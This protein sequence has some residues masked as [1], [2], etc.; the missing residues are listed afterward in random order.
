M[1]VLS[2][3]SV[4]PDHVPAELV[5]EDY[6]FVFGTITEADP[7]NELA[8]SVHQG[9]DIIYATNAYPGRTGAWVPR[10]M[11]DLRAIY[12][13]PETFSS[14]GFS[15]FAA[16]IGDTWINSPLELDPPAHGPFR[17]MLNPAFTPK[18]M[19]ALEDKIRQYAIGYI[20]KFAANGRCEFM[21]QMAFEF[22]IRV[23][24]ELMGLPQDRT[25]EFLEWEQ[26]MLFS[27]GLQ[28]KA[29]AARKVVTYLAEEIAAHRANPRD[30]LISFAINA[31]K[32]G[33]PLTDDEL[34]GFCFNLFIGGLDTVSTHSSLQFAHLAQ[35]PEHQAYL[36]ENPSE[37]PKAIEEFMR[38]YA[39][40]T[41]SRICTRDVVFNGIQFKKGDKV[42]T[43][44]TLAGRDP[45][46][47]EDPGTIRFDRQ[48]RHTGFGFGIHTCIGMHLA[49][50]ELRIALE[51]FL[52]RISPFALQPGH[53]LRYRLGMVQPVELP[54]VWEQP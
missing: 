46:E 2:P 13:D 17:Q 27:D 24:M 14:T 37:I 7:F 36:R 43:S 33:Q 34:M 41:T 12:M 10:R 1:A 25:A 52:A 6:P 15:Q 8:A 53:K 54:L 50:R 35:H 26:G 39:G 45:D 4:V 31:R 51:E 29:E 3:V 16:L 18:T 30:D 23:F 38:A 28:P 44:P 40:V 5:R 20:E 21:S 22:P 48:P 9:P 47:F 42:M 19:A 11:R 49:K 32:E